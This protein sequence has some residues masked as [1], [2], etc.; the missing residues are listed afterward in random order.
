M[1]L[2]NTVITGT[3][4]YIPTVRVPNSSFVAQKFYEPNGVPIESPGEVIIEKFKDITGIEE[5]RYGEDHLYASDFAAFAAEEAI[6]SA[7]IDRESIDQIIMAHNMGDMIKGTNQVDIMPCLAARVKNKLGIHNTSCIPY[8]MLF[9]CPGWVQGVI[10]ADSYIRSGLAKRCLVIGSDN[11]SRTLDAYDRDSMI[12]GDG[13]GAAIVEGVDGL[14]KQGVLGISMMS[15]TD[16]HASFLYYGKSNAPGS[17]PNVRF[18]K[19]QG[20]RIYEYSLSKVPGAMK[21]A[22]D[23]AG[24]DIGQVKKVII[25]QANEKMDEAIIQRFY[26]M[27]GIHTLDPN[28]LPMNIHR[29]GNSSVA[30]VPTLY[31]MILKGN[32]PGHTISRGDVIIFASVGAGMAINCIVYR[33]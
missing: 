18:L 25:H 14:E 16:E 29:L 10:Q 13:A 27:Y 2:L 12:F 21:V 17:D 19:M 9:G 30:T 15:H 33:Q 11:L 26:R 3:G 8:D 28:V 22:V 4:C 1:K 31:D 32:Q 24:I 23:R 20:R 6:K 5:R 7:G